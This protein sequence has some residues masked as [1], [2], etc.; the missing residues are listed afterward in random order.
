MVNNLDDQRYIFIFLEL[1]FAWSLLAQG[2]NFLRTVQNQ[3]PA[4]F[5]LLL[6]PLSGILLLACLAH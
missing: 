3:F 1:F 2:G 4:H 6:A 5:L